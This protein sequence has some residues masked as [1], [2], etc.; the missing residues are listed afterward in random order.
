[1]LDKMY[2]IIKYCLIALICYLLLRILLKVRVT[3][4]LFSRYPNVA[5]LEKTHFVYGDGYQDEE[6]DLQRHIDTML[7]K[8][9]TD[10]LV[11][12][13]YS[14]PLIYLTSH[15]AIKQFK[16]QVPVSIDR[17]DFEKY[18][19][20]KLYPTSF[21]KKKSSPKWRQRQQVFFKHG[22]LKNPNE[23]LPLMV[24]CLEER[25]NYWSVK[26]T[27]N[28]S[29]NSTE[30]DLDFGEEMSDLTLEVVLLAIF[31]EDFLDKVAA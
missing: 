15:E 21:D 28:S 4:L 14:T 8:P 10:I 18:E 24:D 29:V 13:D 7:V 2:S 25:V 19:F 12:F 27:Y 6:Y 1:M 17:A 22:L 31:G 11:V 30:K 3:K 16:K 9:S 23:L 26:P 20:G 5:M